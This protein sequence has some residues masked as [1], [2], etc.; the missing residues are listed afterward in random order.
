[1]RTFILIFLS[2]ILIVSCESED[3]SYNP[4]LEGIYMCE[5]SINTPGG[6][7]SCDVEDMWCPVGMTGFVDPS[8][9]IIDSILNVSFSSPNTFGITNFYD[10]EQLNLLSDMSIEND[11]EYSMI[12]GSFYGQD[13]LS[14]HVTTVKAAYEAY[15]ISSSF[16]EVMDSYYCVKQ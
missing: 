3:V 10:S 11:N 4:E 13:S 9:Q 8:E 14:L 5:A 7:W 1:M 12:S 2:S 6:F 15:G 16:G